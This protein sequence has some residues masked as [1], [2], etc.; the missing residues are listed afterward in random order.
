VGGCRTYGMK[1][2]ERR[3]LVGKYA[4]KFPLEGPR[5]RLKDITKTDIKGIESF[6]PD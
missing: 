6:A 4:G 1:R 5:R 3:D 2:N